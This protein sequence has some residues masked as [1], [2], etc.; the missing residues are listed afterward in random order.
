MHKVSIQ[1][2]IKVVVENE[3]SPDV[4]SVLEVHQVSQRIGM[5]MYLHDTLIASVRMKRRVFI[6]QVRFIRVDGKQSSCGGKTRRGW[7]DKG[8]QRN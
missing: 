6:A 3:K 5:D 4:V 8:F 1:V 7:E 2:R